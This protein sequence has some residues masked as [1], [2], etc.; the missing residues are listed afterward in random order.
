VQSL[1]GGRG[2]G[3]EM[4][5]AAAADGGES[6]QSLRGG[7]PLRGGESLRG[8]QPLRRGQSMQPLRTG[9]CG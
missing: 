2:C 7:Q 3:I 1:R 5:R 4:R 8:G 6:V 9:R